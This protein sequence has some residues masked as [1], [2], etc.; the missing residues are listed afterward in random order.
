MSQNLIQTSMAAGELAPSIFAHTDMAKYHA[1]MALMRNWFVDYRSGASTRAG[2]KFVIQALKSSTPVRLIPFQTSVLVPYILE[3][4]DGYVRPISN[5]GAVLEAPFAITAIT[6]ANPAVVSVP[7]NNFVAG[8]WL[9]VVGVVGMTAVNGRFYLAANVAGPL[10]TLQTV[11][12][13]PVNSLGYPAWTSGGTISRV[14]KFASP[15]AAADLALVKYVQETNIM[16]LTHPNYSEQTLTFTAPTN[17]SIAAAVFGTTVPAPTGLGAATTPAGS[18]NYSYIVTAVDAS[19]HESLPSTAVALPSAVNLGT[20]AGTNTITWSAAAGA[21][22]YNV[23]KAELSIAGAVPAGQAYGFI[24]NSTSLT[25][26]DSNIVPDFS[27]TPP[28]FTNPFSAGNNPGTACYFQQRLYRGGSNTQPQ[29]FWG[30]QPGDYYNMNV[31]DPT[32]ADDAITGTIVSRQVNAIKSMLPM[33]GGLVVLTAN[34]AWQINSGSGVASTSAVTP[35]NATAT[36]QA[37][38]GASDVPPIISNYDVLYVQAKGSIVR[39][40]TY[41]L[42]ANIYTGT[43]I[44]ILSNHLFFNHQILEWAYAEEPFKVVWCVREDGNLLSLTFIKE[45]EV[46]GWAHHDTLGLYKSVASVTEGMVDATYVVVQRFIGGLWVQMIERMD[47]RTFV[48]GAED[49]WCVDCG[50]QSGLVQPVAGLSASGSIGSVTFSA[51]APVFSAQSVGQILRMGGGIAKITQFLSTSQVVGTITQRITATLPNDPSLTPVPATAGNW[52][53]TPQFTVFQGLDY[54]EGQTVSILADG[55]VITPQ[56]VTNGTI[57]L[58]QAASKVTVGL[59]YVP[60]LQTMP[61]DVGGG[62]TIQ[63]KRKKI[64]ALSL[65]LNNTRGLSVGRTFAKA[66]PMKEINPDVLLGQA[67]P[68]VNGIERIIVD[69]LWDVPGQVCIQQDNPLPATV[70]G[71]VPEI[72]LGDTGK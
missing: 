52:S 21:S 4:G 15:Y 9:Y 5:G 29:T 63:G 2:T 66:V 17:W 58:A 60:Q 31:S 61:L 40:L 32:E 53:I 45:Q 62:E 65:F 10:V 1:G 35:I 14:Y 16:T 48:Y 59:K 18:A 70:L 51:T 26:I 20:T 8:D 43:D 3:F 55:G 72:I 23:Y 12:G 22:S 71:V 56:V 27:S 37:Y 42:Y 25:F 34:G 67:I 30:S 33:P 68:L 64:A 7:G 50:L 57:T 24:G 44:S 13:V 41:N 19:G 46:Y 38:N 49:S 28:I 47:N 11:N 36:P 6:Q 39:D 54:L 69:S